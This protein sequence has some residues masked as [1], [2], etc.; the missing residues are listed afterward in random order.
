MWSRFLGMAI[1]LMINLV[2]IVFAHVT[3][4]LMI[5]LVSTVC[6]RVIVNG[7]LKLKMHVVW[8]PGHG[9]RY[10]DQLGGHLNCS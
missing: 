3:I 10:H 1:V 9:H 2:G 8:I 5:G 6:T 4:I 7:R